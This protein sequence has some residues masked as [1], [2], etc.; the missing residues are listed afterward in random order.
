MRSP[1]PVDARIALAATLARRGE[2]AVAAELGSSPV[3][4]R[5]ARN[6]EMLNPTTIYALRAYLAHEALAA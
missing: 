5:R 2:I 6:G 4:V 1:L 3:T